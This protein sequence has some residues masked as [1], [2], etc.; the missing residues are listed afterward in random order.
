MKG[1]IM[2]NDKLDNLNLEQ[3]KELRDKLKD[4]IS[5]CNTQQLNRKILANAFYGSL[6][7]K[8]SRWYDIRIPT[9]ITK[10]G[11]DY[12]KYIAKNVSDFINE[13]VGNNIDKNLIVS[14][15]TDSIFVSVYDYVKKYCQNM[16]KKEIVEK[17]IEFDK[18]IQLFISLKLKEYGKKHN[19]YEDLIDMKR[20][21]I[22]DKALWVAKKRYV[23]KVLVDE[24]N[25]Y[26]ENRKYKLKGL[27]LVKSNTP[28]IVKKYLFNSLEYIMNNDFKGLY[29]YVT[30]IKKEWVDLTPEEIAFPTIV[31][32][33]KYW[34]RNKDN[35]QL[36]YKKGA[37][38]HVKGSI[39]FNELCMKNKLNNDLIKDKDKIKYVYLLDN[40]LKIDSL[41]FKNEY[42]IELLEKKYIDYNEHFEKLF[43]DKIKIM[44]KSL[45]W[46]LDN[47]EKKEIAKKFL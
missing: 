44:I 40:P 17:L 23:Y 26:D 47:V 42:P 25:V 11:Q 12:I 46:N 19:I 35:L 18:E 27:E 2:M 16:N 22:I 39:F 8:Y 32:M 43:I 24:A 33:E 6:A 45:D 21:N 7:N 15:D 9:S 36:S 30:T 37:Q 10:T 4:K 38:S 34:N 28:K 3:L 31:N 41:S 13:K 1:Q 5:F 29:Q 20:E 14:G